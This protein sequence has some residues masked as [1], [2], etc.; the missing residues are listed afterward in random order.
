[1][2]SNSDDCF[3]FFQDLTRSIIWPFSWSERWTLCLTILKTQIAK[4]SKYSG[5]L[6][7]YEHDYQDRNQQ[8]SWIIENLQNTD[9]KVTCSFF[10]HLRNGWTAISQTYCS[11]TS[12]RSPRKV[13][14]NGKLFSS[15]FQFCSQIPKI[16]LI[17]RLIDKKPKNSVKKTV[18][19]FLGP[20]FLSDTVRRFAAPYNLPSLL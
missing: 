13:Y 16:R 1:M 14:I 10:S 2:L 11:S 8:N 15:A 17:T 5:E 7:K 18:S 3:I 20:Y 12:A 19:V 6:N 4:I 9:N